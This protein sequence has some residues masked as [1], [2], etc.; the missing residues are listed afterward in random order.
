VVEND[1]TALLLERKLFDLGLQVIWL[2]GKLPESALPLAV[3]TLF[4]AGFIVLL[5]DAAD[6]TQWPMQV[7][8]L[9]TDECRN[10]D[11]LMDKIHQL[12]AYR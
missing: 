9:S 6:F 3:V 12:V 4:D 10:P 11:R 5:T 8:H 7:V 2:N 1:E